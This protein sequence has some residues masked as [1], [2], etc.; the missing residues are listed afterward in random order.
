MVSGNYS[1][2]VWLEHETLT[3]AAKIALL[4]HAETQHEEAIQY[5]TDKAHD[6]YTIA[7]AD[8]R[9]ARTPTHPSGR[10][11]TGHGC[12]L[13]AATVNG[14]T[15]AQVL[16]AAFPTGSMVMFGAGTLPE[17]WE[18][19]DG[20]GGNPNMQGYIPKGAGSGVTPGSTGGSNSLTPTAS[21]FTNPDCT[22][23]DN[24]I[25]R[26]QHTYTD[27]YNDPFHGNDADGWAANIGNPPTTTISRTT[28][29]TSPGNYTTRTAHN[30]TG[31][32]ITWTGYLDS[33]GNSVSGALD[34]RPACRTVRFIRRQ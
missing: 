25:P 4:N 10:S 18:V 19:C 31:S 5:M 28:E 15:L 13:D 29:D 27:N 7:E 8:A 24:Q 23:T 20:A 17:N 9:Y 3:E 11:D 26:H 6:F 21:A 34:I 22:L 1:A 30:H 14:Y 16:A 12:G 2:H 33:G 32:Y